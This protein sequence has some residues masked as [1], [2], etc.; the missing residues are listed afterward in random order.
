MS[1]EYRPIREEERAQF[2]YGGLIGFGD[3]TAD[4]EVNRRLAL[5]YL[6]PEETL[7]AFV[8]G[9]LASKM[10]THPFTMRWNGRDIGCGGVSAVTTSPAFRRQGHLRELMTRAF[11]TM[12]EHSQP[13]AMLWASM[14]AI[15]QRFGYG[16]AYTLYNSDF[17]PRTLHFVDTVATPGRLRLVK[18]TEAAVTVA[19]VYDRF[20]APR[21]LM[22]QRG[23]ERWQSVFRQWR[24]EDPPKLVAT[25]EENGEVLGYT[26]YSVESRQLDRPGPNQRLNVQDFVWVKPAAHRALMGYFA[27]HDLVYSVRL[28]IM[29]T[30]DP[31][32]QH[33]AEPRLLNLAARDGTLVRIVDV[34]AA[35]EGRGYDHDGRLTFSLADELC[36]WNTGSWDLQVEGG[37]ARVRASSGDGALCLTPRALAILAS[38]NATAT[39]LARN[40]LIA[41]A[42]PAALRMADDLFRI[43]YA[44]MCMDEF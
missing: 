36:P 44:P 29:P 32:M 18:H 6:R 16:I 12:R 3:T 21:T 14:A 42:D 22:L 17:D 8:D 43:A 35:L 34:A 19:G 39:T 20:V 24:P 23:E 41:G 26:V 27:G 13:V 7:C 38:G 11:R 2:I 1:V 10:R 28:T 15:Y 25:Y 4:A 9:E 40:G 37:A 33:A 5:R 30:D 31:L